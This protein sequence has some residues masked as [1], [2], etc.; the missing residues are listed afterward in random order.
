M[1]EH[2]SKPTGRSDRTSRNGFIGWLILLA[3]FAVPGVI[4]M[5]NS[6]NTEDFAKVR[7]LEERLQ[8]SVRRGDA[9]QWMRCFY[10]PTEKQ[11]RY[12]LKV[13][14]V[15]ES[16]GD[17]KKDALIE[18]VRKG[19]KI[20]V[21]EMRRREAG[22]WDGTLT[23]AM[24]IGGRAVRTQYHVTFRFE[25]GAWYLAPDRFIEETRD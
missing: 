14:E 23:W 1:A 4:L 7:I 3:V 25:D 16:T 22:A 21:S 20:S 8:D 5:K 24:E 12:L 2:E 15:L 11:K 9:E 6:S 17:P 13:F 18:T 10:R 19:L